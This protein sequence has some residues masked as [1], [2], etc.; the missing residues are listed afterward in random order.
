M[1]LA[2]SGLQGDLPVNR[3]LDEELVVIYDGDGYCSRISDADPKSWGIH[4]YTCDSQPQSHSRELRNE[5][6]SRKTNNHWVPD[7]SECTVGVANE[8]DFV[9]CQEVLQEECS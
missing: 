5:S 1:R 9:P 2:I 6:I 4:R 3:T 7:H 8:L